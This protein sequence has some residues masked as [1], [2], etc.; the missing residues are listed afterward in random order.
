MNFIPVII[1]NKLIYF[2]NKIDF[3]FDFKKEIKL[4]FI[5]K[6]QYPCVFFNIYMFE[7]KYDK[8]LHYL[9]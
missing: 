4:I 1:I 5:L 6:I 2:I 3:D 7:M 9:F 8:L